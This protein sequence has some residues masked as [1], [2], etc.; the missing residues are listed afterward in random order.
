MK[1][2]KFSQKCIKQAEVSAET[3]SCW[4]VILHSDAQNPILTRWNLAM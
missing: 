4:Q 2:K 3:F 1:D